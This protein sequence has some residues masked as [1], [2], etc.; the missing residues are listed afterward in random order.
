MRLR[1]KT[2]A[3]IPRIHTCL[4]QKHLTNAATCFYVYNV[5]ISIHVVRQGLFTVVNY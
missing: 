2:Y 1:Y 3:C 5:E 4:K